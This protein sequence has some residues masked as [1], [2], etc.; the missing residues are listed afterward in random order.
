MRGI[1]IPATLGPMT[2]QAIVFD[3]DGTLLNTLEDLTRACNHVL[4]VN[5]RPPIRDT[6]CRGMI[7]NGT[8][9]LVQRATRLEGPQLQ[10]GFRQFLDH[11]DAHMYDHTVLYP[12]IAE[13]LDEL[14]ERGIRLAILSNKPHPA[15]RG[16][17]ERFLSRWPFEQ[18]YGHREEVPLKPD[19]TSALQ[20]SKALGIAP[21]DCVFV[22]DSGEDMITG[23]AAG[24]T[25]VAVSWGFRDVP[26]L[27][28]KGADAIIHKP[29]ELLN[30]I[31]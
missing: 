30:F 15:T 25:A 3:L 27:H 24:M 14:V 4:E 13:L 18:V 5:G 17:A 20:I 21:Q 19:P 10:T 6:D 16:M 31:G 26:E 23:K 28:E 22:G 29:M 11:Y 9:T 7:G 8:I 2:H 12:G 1:N